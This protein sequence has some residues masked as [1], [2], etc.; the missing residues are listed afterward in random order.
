M[1]QTFSAAD[2][3]ENFRMSQLTVNNLCQ[4]LRSVIEKQSTRL[5]SPLSVE[6]HVAVTLWYL[7]TPLEFRSNGHL[8]GI[9]H[10]TAY[11]V[12]VVHETCAAI[13]QVLL[14]SYIN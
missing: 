13:V 9:A 7:A 11:A 2:W 12:A 1:L 6:K 14:K 4:R 3:I 8:F 5:R 10:S